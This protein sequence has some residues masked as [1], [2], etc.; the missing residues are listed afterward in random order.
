MFWDAI[1]LRL[2]GLWIC[3]FLFFVESREKEQGG[4][5][6][7]A[8]IGDVEGGPPAAAGGHD[9]FKAGKPDADEVDDIAF[10]QARPEAF[11]GDALELEALQQSVGEIAENPC[12]QEADS[13]ARGGVDE[14]S[15]FPEMADGEQREDWHEE[16]Y[17]GCPGGAVAHAKSDAL[18][19]HADD[20][21]PRSQLDGAKAEAGFGELEHDPPFAHLIEHQEWQGDP[22]K[23]LAEREVHTIFLTENHD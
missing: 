13:N 21:K 22:A 20:V 11:V 12:E 1:S 23:E 7:D 3:F 17:D 2:L 9:F 10:G 14:E 19:V 16:K 8:G 4:G 15:F 6:A 5:D 18:V